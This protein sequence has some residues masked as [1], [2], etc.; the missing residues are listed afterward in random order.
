M[1]EL[2]GRH[3]ECQELDQLVSDVIGGASRALVLS[4][5]PGVGKTALLSY[6]SQ[7]VAGWQVLTTA[8]VESEMELPYSGLQQL[9]APLLDDLD[10]LPDPQRDALATVFGV[11]AAP[12]PD[13]FMIGL[14]TLTLLAQAAERAALICVVDDAQ[15]LDPASAQIIAFV[16]RRL[17]AE[18][19]ALICAARTGSGEDVLG[20]LPVLTI[21]GL[22]DSHA[23]PLLLDNLHGPLDA[24]VIDQIVAESRGNPLALLELPRAWR[25]TDLAGGF[26]LP[27]KIERSYLRRL[28]ELPADAQLLTLI[29]AADPVGDA[30]LIHRA[31]GALG[32]TTAAAKPAVDAGILHI[33]GRVAFAH[34]LARSS[35]YGA[36]TTA[37]RR[38]AHQIL[39]DVTDAETDPDRRAWHR[40]RATGTPNEAVAAELEQSADRAA[41]RAGLAAAAAFL[42]RATE[43]TPVRSE[44]TRRALAA[45]SANVL[46]GAFDTAQ[47]MIAIAETGSL[48]EAQRAQVE[49][50]R[51]Q[52]AFGSSRGK[53]A[54]LLMLAAA[55][56]LQ[57]LNLAAAR[58]TYLDAFSAAQFAGRY[59]EGVGTTEIARA[60]RTAELP[61]DTERTPGDL[62]L[63]AFAAITDDYAAA[64]PPGQAA[65]EGLRTATEPALRWLWQGSVLALELWDDDSAY[66]LSERHLRIARRTGTLTEL[67]LALGSHTPILVFT[68]Q[69]AA[70]ATLAEEA[71]SVLAAAEIAEAPY[72]ALILSAWQGNAHD[73]LDLIDSATRGA[74]ERGEGIGVAI[75]EYSRAVLCNG[76]GRY[77]D[78]FVAG[79][80]ACLDPNELVAHNWAMAELIEAAVRTGQLGVAQETLA[81]LTMKAAA[82]RTDWALGIE[83]RSRALL[84]EH[85]PEPAFR[86]AIKRLGRS[87][88]RAE[89]ARAHLLYGE[90]LRRTKRRTDARE[91]L[92]T[93]EDMF[94]AMGMGAFAQ[95][96]ARELLATGATPRKRTVDTSSDL[97]AQEALVAR[98]AREGLS[99]PQIGAELFLS[100]RT[101]E[102]H[103]GRIFGKLGITS[104]RE[105]RDVLSDDAASTDSAP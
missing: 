87:R 97:T 80:N 11:G 77:D 85:D 7:Q 23:R 57:P 38:R 19:I 51:A 92:T 17:L 90:W 2:V 88:I 37:D 47:A 1:G 95:R 10:Q 46:A 29:A 16:S 48:D 26:S 56:R 4:G 9:C 74:A 59:D 30:G 53:E 91:Q 40:A 49:L 100:A 78:A 60:Y 71:Q 102:W 79:R 14:G 61:P 54:M 99:N 25:E 58:Q 81:R 96:C 43:L 55:R 5:E 101:V 72:G 84:S 24:A 82:C 13:R 39:A 76:L 89:L 69:L 35:V 75:C 65:L 50:V 36:A 22:D 3:A 6:L 15:W 98:L 93:A 20:G 63:D 41:A 12:A 64:V 42:A 31:A 86:E 34:P 32:L 52:L 27:G 18:R 45:A 103:L 62:L 21:E 94:T 105:L 66:V 83:A 44:L 68:G 28:E 33:N 8:G 73:A 104:R 70:A 67:P